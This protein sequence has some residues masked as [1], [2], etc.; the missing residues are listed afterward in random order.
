MTGVLWSFLIGSLVLNQV[1]FLSAKI[2]SFIVQGL[3]QPELGPAFWQ[4]Y[5]YAP[6][7]QPESYLFVG[8][9]YV[10][11][12]LLVCAFGTAVITY[13]FAM[14]P[15]IDSSDVSRTITTT[16][17]WSTLWVLLVH[18]VISLVEFSSPS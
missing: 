14:R 4:I 7:R 2:A 18:L 1:A 12:R 8:F 15:K 5:F 17:L 10:L 13:A 9:F 3:L 6:L 11:A 16:I